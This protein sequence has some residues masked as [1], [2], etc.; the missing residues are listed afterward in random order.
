MSERK[1]NGTQREW[2]LRQSNRLFWDKGYAETSMK[3]IANACG[4]RPAN[5]YN[6][7]ECKE[8]IL[9][10]NLLQEMVEIVTPVR[11]LKDDENAD[12]VE[13]L[14]F[15]IKNHVTLTLGEMSS[16]KLLFDV[17]LKNLSAEN[18]KKI[19]KLRDEYDAIGEAVIRRGVRKGVFSPVD[20]KIAVFSIASVIARSRIWYSPKG[21]YTVDDIVDFIFNFTMNGIGAGKKR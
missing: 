18:R 20:E 3:D 19:I 6:F 17:G 5:I 11:H 16:S 9:F 10:E 14:R 1:K 7:F 21:K 4:F 12:P 8:S 13:S 15:F 2:I